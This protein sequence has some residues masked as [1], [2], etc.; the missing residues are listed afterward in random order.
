MQFK[1]ALVSHPTGIITFLVLVYLS[2]KLSFSF[3]TERD[4]I[5]ALR[6][7]IKVSFLKSVKSTSDSRVFDTKNILGQ[8]GNVSVWTICSHKCGRFSISP[9]TGKNSWWG[10]SSAEKHSTYHREYGIR[11][12]PSSI[13][14]HTPT[15]SHAHTCSF[16]YTQMSHINTHSEPHIPG[17]RHLDTHMLKHSHV[18]KY[19]D[20]ET[21]IPSHM[22]THTH[23][24]CHTPCDLFITKSLITKLKNNVLQI[25]QK[26]GQLKNMSI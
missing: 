25:W 13:C 18:H 3:S 20:S 23:T 19:I 6:R 26:F 1:T 8:G 9:D 24:L 12:L 21:H 16:S 2:S 22:D 4:S 10:C 15:H 7:E 17:H 11:T 14:T 5:A